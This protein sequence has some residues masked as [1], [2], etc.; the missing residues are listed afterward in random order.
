MIFKTFQDE[1]V[2]VSKRGFFHFYF[3]NKAKSDSAIDFLILRAQ[4][5]ISHTL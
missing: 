5:S 1:M 2:I 3:Q 4:S